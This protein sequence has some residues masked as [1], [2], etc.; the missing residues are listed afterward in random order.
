M[1]LILENP[2]INNLRF[3]GFLLAPKDKERHDITIQQEFH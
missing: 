2:Q 1:A 3:A